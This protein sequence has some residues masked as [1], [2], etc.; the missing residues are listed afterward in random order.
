MELQLVSKETAILAKELGFDWNVSSYYLNNEEK[1][2]YWSPTPIRINFNTRN[3]CI[4]APEQELLAKWLRDVHGFKIAVEWAGDKW[5]GYITMNIGGNGF[6]KPTKT[7][8]IYEEAMEELL[9]ISLLYLKEQQ[10]E[11]KID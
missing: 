6:M 2:Y 11:M 8:E 10:E 1:K 5:K 9:S 7:T 4:S 3:E